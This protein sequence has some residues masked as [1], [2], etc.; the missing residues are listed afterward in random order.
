MLCYVIGTLEYFCFVFSLH[1]VS[2]C[3][4]FS[5]SVIGLSTLLT[6]C[7]SELRRRQCLSKT[8]LFSVY[9]LSG[10]GQV[11]V[12]ICLETPLIKNVF[13]YQGC[14]EDPIIR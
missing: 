12:K 9:E 5:V 8:S 2:V 10:P 11:L 3:V 6:V 7:S 1:V 4:S 13:K 14:H